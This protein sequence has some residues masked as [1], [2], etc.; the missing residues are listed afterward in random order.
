MKA[1]II[2]PTALG[3]LALGIIGNTAADPGAGEP[4]AKPKH[5]LSHLERMRECLEHATE[6]DGRDLNFRVERRR[7]AGHPL[8]RVWNP[9]GFAGI[10]GWDL[11]ARIS[12]QD[13]PREAERFVRTVNRAGYF[14][15]SRMGRTVVVLSTTDV[16]AASAIGDCLGETEELS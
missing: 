15:A 9:R 5:R 11:A 4:A 3:V 13:S 14:A 6:P 16:D 12:Q 8:I 1:K 7:G 10:K 2:I